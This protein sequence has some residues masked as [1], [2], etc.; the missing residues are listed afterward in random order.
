MFRK[1][2]W[3]LLL[4]LFLLGA[5]VGGYYFYQYKTKQLI[6][7]LIEQFSPIAD[8]SVN[9]INVDLEGKAELIGVKISP[10]GYEDEVLIDQID[11]I[12]G[13]VW[14]PLAANTWFKDSL[15]QNLNL[16]L[17]SIIFN[18][19]AD[20]FDS[21]EFS[22]KQATIQKT[23]WGLACAEEVNFVSLA[24]SLGL[25]KLQIDS[26]IKLQATNANRELRVAVAFNAP[27]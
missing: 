8:I 18:L 14:S 9:Q 20:F 1:A 16:Q 13:D 5:L 25:A 15:P 24:H 10:L 12:T 11:I 6:V 2:V 21:N 19:D 7:E 22:S 17:S 23:I 27:G 26:Q 4:V 3:F